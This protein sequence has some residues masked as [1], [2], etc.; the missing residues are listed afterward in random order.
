MQSEI[1]S[2]LLALRSAV[3]RMVNDTQF[4]ENEWR[5]L[6][7]I[8]SVFGIILS[9]IGASFLIANVMIERTDTSSN[10]HNQ[11]VMMGV[12]LV[13]LNIPL[14]LLGIA[15]RKRSQPISEPKPQA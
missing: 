3:D 6:G 14:M 7:L 12:M 5:K 15:L 8:S 1:E 2:E 11:L 10:F 13:V 4:R 9:L